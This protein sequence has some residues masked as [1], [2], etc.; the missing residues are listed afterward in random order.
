MPHESGDD[1]DKSIVK[2][3]DFFNDS[4]IVCIKQKP[5]ER[6]E[7]EITIT[8]IGNRTQIHRSQTICLTT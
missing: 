8:E 3:H 1:N 6:A 7:T 2:S 4:D 5:R